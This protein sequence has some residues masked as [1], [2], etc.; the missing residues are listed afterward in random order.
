[1][2][3]RPRSDE[4][5]RRLAPRIHGLDAEA[6]ASHQRARLRAAMIELVV[7]HGY[8]AVR[9]SDVIRLA[10]VSRSTFYALYPD[11]EACF[12]DAYDE[13]SR[14]VMRAVLD[15]HRRARGAR[16]PVR[17]ALGAFLEFAAAEPDTA[18]FLIYGGLGGSLGLER[19]NRAFLA[20]VRR[21]RGRPGA[22]RDAPDDLTLRAVLGGVREVVA[23]RLR[24]GEAAGL[25]ALTD[26]LTA[27]ALSYPPA[28]PPILA[29][30]A[31]RAVEPPERPWRADSPR[32]RFARLPSG[33]HDL[34]RELVAYSQ[35]E[36]I[37]DALADI[38]AEKG[39]PGL[40]VTEIA[41]RAGVSHQTF[42]EH[43]PGKREAYLAAGRTGGE[44][45]FQA[46]VEAYAVHVGEWPRAVAAGLEAYLRFLAVEPGY[47]RLGFVDIFT[48]DPEM[49]Q[50]RDETVAAFVAYLRPGFELA[51]AAGDS[52][53]PIALDAIG[54]AVWELLQYH[55]RHEPIE[56]LPLLAPQATYLALT[57]FLGAQRAARVAVALPEDA[58]GAAGASGA[59][60]A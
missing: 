59:G 13:T 31:P 14:R 16:G 36:R 41:R 50:L 17:A 57:P 22:G 53:P 3:S 21:L 20:L 1:M 47:A 2:S 30:R 15:A 58:A 60:A 51:A 39:Y 23:I 34:T 33:R 18:A 52:V 54:G 49:L 55:I 9:G 29:A 46:A 11:K 25:P 6:V 24:R 37:L 32:G 42:Y 28:A 43:F 4:R 10:H 56:R 26:E 19:Y 12:L 48:A 44:W 38:V 27:W 8:H 5:Y 45:G 35:R 7:Q 40:T